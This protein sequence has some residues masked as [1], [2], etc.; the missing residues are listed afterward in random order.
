MKKLL[1]L[2]ALFA[3][4]LGAQ[5]LPMTYTDTHDAN[6]DVF[7]TPNSGVHGFT[8]DINDDGF[9]ASRDTVLS[10]M[11]DI[12]VSDDGDYD[13]SRTNYYRVTTWCGRHSAFGRYHCH[14]A[15]RSYTTPGQ[16]ETLEV[17][18]DGKLFG[19][20]EVDYNPLG[21]AV[22]TADVQTD[23]LLAVTLRAISGDLWFRDSRLTVN[24]DRRVSVPEPATMA[25]F[26]LCLLGFGVTQARRRRP[27][28]ATR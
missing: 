15:T 28:L 24:V 8:H 12:G 7:L 27:A 20:Y 1:S 3:L 6:P 22:D 11:L 18:A 13:Y 19:N 4:P 25:L 14:Y 2:A 5:A 16:P 21:F 9:D 17:T 23:G 26:G 10:V